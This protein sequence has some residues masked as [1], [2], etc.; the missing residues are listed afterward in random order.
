MKNLHYMLFA[1]MFCIMSCTRPGSKATIFKADKNPV[2]DGINNEWDN[3][4]AHACAKVFKDEEKGFNGE[5]DLDAYW[6]AV[7][8][9]SGLFILVQITKDDVPFK[10]DPMDEFFFENDVA[11]IYINVNSSNLKDG[12]G[13]INGKGHYQFSGRTNDSTIY[14]DK[15]GTRSFKVTRNDPSNNTYCQELFI[16]FDEL[17]DSNEKPAVAHIGQIF[18]FDISITDND[19]PANDYGNL[20]DNAHPEKKFA[21]KAWANNKS[22]N[23]QSNWHNM[24]DA[25]IIVLSDKIAIIGK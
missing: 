14:F 25:G 22:G 23:H 5:N 8:C 24:D 19:G 4:E 6:K 11:E 18:G 16:A 7:W 15:I 13:A 20:N 17:K 10:G 9:D 2:V 21:R 12:F 3:I 1:A